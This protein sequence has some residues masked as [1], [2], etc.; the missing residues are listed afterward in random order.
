MYDVTPR[1]I[2][3]QNTNGVGISSL[4]Y[5][6]STKVVRVYLNQTFSTP[7]EFP[8]IVGKKI[9][10]ENVSILS[11][12]TGQGYNSSDYNY[13]LFPI[14]TSVP[15]FGGTGAMLSI[16][17]KMYLRLEKFQVLLTH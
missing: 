1:I 4:T 2:P 15:Q 9:L 11:S 12:P 17:S 16:V 13:T 8:Y 3:T 14:I 10:V 6:S 7:R 5:D